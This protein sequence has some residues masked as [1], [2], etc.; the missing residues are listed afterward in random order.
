MDNSIVFDA[1]TNK[2]YH[3]ALSIIDRLDDCR[4]REELNQV[5]KTALIPLLDCSGAFYAQLEGELNTPQLLDDIN[6]SSLCQHS[7]KNFLEANAQTQMFANSTTSDTTTRLATDA[8]CCTGQK[9]QH[10][11]ITNSC[12]QVDHCCAIVALF[13]APRPTVALYFCRLKPYEHYY[14]LRDFELL[15]FL[16]TT[17]LQSI[18]TI[19]FQEECQNVEQMKN[20][21]FGHVEPMAL[22]RDNEVLVYTNHA[23]DQAFKQCSFTHLSIVFSQASKIEPE[24]AKQHS[25]RSKLGRRLYEVTVTPVKDGANNSKRLYLLSFSRVTNKNGKILRQL[26]EAGLTDRE[27]E[28]ATLIYQ[29]ISTRNISEQLNLSYHTVRNHIKHIY[30]KMNVSS[31]SEM[32]TW[33]G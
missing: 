12:H 5:L 15:Q 11:S 21:M 3:S 31:R 18:K 33:E 24:Q 20:H 14:S 32:L 8:F 7:W 23:F 16:R 4:T 17:L 1:L 2:D 29:G 26:S 19:M 13:D 9:C 22:V 10:C 30:S 27:L 6:Q 25:F 28:I